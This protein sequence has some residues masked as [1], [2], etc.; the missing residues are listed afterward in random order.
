MTVKEVKDEL[1][2][3]LSNVRTLIFKDSQ[4]DIMIFAEIE[5][6]R[7][8]RKYDIKENQAM[9]IVMTAI[10]KFINNN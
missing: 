9:F 10:N 5:A 6:N 4:L 2:L 7:L 8:A 1:D 3:I